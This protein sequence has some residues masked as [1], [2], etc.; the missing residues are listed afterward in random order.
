MKASIPF[1]LFFLNIFFIPFSVFS[2]VTFHCW[3]FNGTTP[4]TSPVNTDNR[5]LGDGEITYTFSNVDNFGGTSLGDCGNGIGDA[6]SPKA[7][8]GHYMTLVFPT[9]DYENIVLSFSVERSASGFT[10]VMLILS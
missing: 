4:F 7:D 10:S 3:D 9:N 2:Q 1:L 6:F 5:V 8:N